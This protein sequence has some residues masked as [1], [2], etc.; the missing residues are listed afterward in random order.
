M[1]R[2]IWTLAIACVVAATGVRPQLE[3]RA[4]ADASE[5]LH[6]PSG[7]DLE[8]LTAS[9]LSAN[10]I[11]SRPTGRHTL[12]RR[13][14]DGSMLAIVPTAASTARLPRIAALATAW[15]LRSFS[16]HLH[17]AHPA[18]GPPALG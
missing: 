18:R 10:R 4:H 16:S 7:A 12:D 17:P 15:S 8:H 6:R 5:Q 13:D 1:L 14:A 9:G 11:A 3:L 2:W